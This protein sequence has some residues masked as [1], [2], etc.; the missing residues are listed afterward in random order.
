MLTALIYAGTLGYGFDYDDYHFVRP[1]TGAEV[2]AAF[3]GTW[4]RTGIEVD[5]YRPLTVALFALRF[6]VLGL[7]ATAYHVLSLLLFALAAALFGAFVFNLFGRRLSPAIAGTALFVAHPAMPYALVCWPTNQMHLA[8]TVTVIAALWWWSRVRTKPFL[9]WT[10]LLLLGVAAAL[11]KEDG[12]LLLPALV[13]LH[14]LHRGIADPRDPPLPVLFSILGALAIAGVLLARAAALHGIGGYA[15]PDAQQAWTNFTKGLRSVVLLVP[16]RRPW[17]LQASWFAAALPLAGLVAAIV[18]RNRAALFCLASGAALTV[19]FNLP[20]ALVSK[21]EQYH[22]LAA[23]AVLMLTGGAVALLDGPRRLLNVIAALILI[24]GVTAMAAV[25]KHIA[26]D[27]QPFGPIV[28]HRDTIVEGWA[29]VP[30]ELRAY[31]ARKREPGAAGRLSPNPIDEL[32]VVSWG[33]LGH[34]QDNRGTP[35]RWLGGRS[36]RILVTSGAS[37]IVIPVRH[38]IELTRE[39]VTVGLRV[40]GREVYRAALA[41]SEWH[42]IRTTLASRRVPLIGRMHEIELRV[43]R[44]WSPAST[45]P[46]SS[47]ARVLGVQV[48]EI[49]IR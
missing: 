19:L 4:D 5:F 39:P 27:F 45:I 2:A 49:E 21:V 15:L 8:E 1:I 40:D 42:P 43:D 20:F 34:E 33:F 13:V 9:W 18:R 30:E 23:G 24:A 32:R 7:N 28:M 16:A 12:V 29:P 41:D 25:S 36:G 6:S 31:L 10:P 11:I 37:S 44:T 47:D 17:Q 22:L 46:G 38:L 14:T 26:G 35:Y 3:T 48:G